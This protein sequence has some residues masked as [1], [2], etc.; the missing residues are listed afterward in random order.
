MDVRRKGRKRVVGLVGLLPR[1]QS[2]FLQPRSGA[3]KNGE[4]RKFEMEPY[5]RKRQDNFESVDC[6]EAGG[7]ETARFSNAR[8]VFE[9]ESRWRARK[10]T[11]SK[12]FMTWKRDT[13]VRMGF[14][15]KGGVW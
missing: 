3:G 8:R 12:L 6:R 11:Q 13:K 14:R 9:L 10:E 5:N 7:N 4:K 1:R 2:V 15:V